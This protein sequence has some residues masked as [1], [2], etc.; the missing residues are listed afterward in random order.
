ML[1]AG[2]VRAFRFCCSTAWLLS[3]AAEY[4][5]VF[6]PRK[7]T[8]FSRPFRI[9]CGLGPMARSTLVSPL[10][11]LCSRDVGC[12]RGGRFL[13]E[14]DVG[15]GVGFANYVVGNAVSSFWQKGVL[16]AIQA[17]KFDWRHLSVHSMFTVCAEV[18]AG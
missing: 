7:Q 12:A 8:S 4:R 9:N 17:R 10:R 5:C 3:L 16:P 2:T 6:R 15:A 13:T 14:R 18:C 11:A 1:V